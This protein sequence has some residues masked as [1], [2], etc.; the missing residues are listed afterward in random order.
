MIEPENLAFLSLD[1]KALYPSMPKHLGRVA[2]EK[3]LNS[4]EDKTIS[5]K[6]ILS[7]LDLCLDNN[8]F[9]F[10]DRTYIQKEGVPIG[11]C[12]A[13]PYACLG[14]GEF[15]K[16]C[17]EEPTFMQTFQTKHQFWRRFIDDILTLFKGNEDE[18][19]QFV[20]FLNSLF[21]G[22]IEFTFEYS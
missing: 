18:A 2:C 11:P 12:M 1:V 8:Y 9:E 10:N 20:D 22:V 13:P 21:P 5:T 6:S 17:F 4:R 19:K 15:E 7:L 14:M 3:Y 16:K